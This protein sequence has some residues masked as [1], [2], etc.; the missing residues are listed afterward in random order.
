MDISKLMEQA[1]KM[2]ENMKSSTD[3]LDKIIVEG[4][5]GGGIV[6]VKMNG[7]MKLINVSLDDVV[8]TDKEML[9]DLITGAV[10]NAISEAKK[11]SESEMQKKAGDALGGMDLKGFKFPGL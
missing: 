4:S 5:S 6:S 2:Q 11:K 7:N 1:K 10:N 3:E 9:E 8:L